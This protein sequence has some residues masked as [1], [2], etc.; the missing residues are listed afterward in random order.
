MHYLDFMNFFQEQST[1][2]LSKFAHRRPLECA[3]AVRAHAVEHDVARGTDAARVLE[4]CKECCRCRLP[5]M[6]PRVSALRKGFQQE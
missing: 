4:R 3:A 5:V 2:N 6:P 1:L